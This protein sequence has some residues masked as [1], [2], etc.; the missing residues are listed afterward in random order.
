MAQPSHIFIVG[1]PRS[2]TSVLRNAL[3]CSKNVAICGETHFLG[4][5][6][7]SSSL[8]RYVL[9]RPEKVADRG[10][11]FLL[12]KRPTN[13]G[14]RQAFAKVGDISTDTGAKKVVD[15]IYNSRPTFWRW[16]AEHV[17]REE[18]LHRL[19]ESDRTDRALLDLLMAFY[20][21]GKPIR[22][23]KTPDHI[24]H[25]PTLLEWFPKAKIVHTF[26]DLRAVFVSLREKILKRQDIS[27]RHR[28]LRKS[29][30]LYEAHLSINIAIHWLRVA[31]LHHQ[32][33]QLYPDNYYFC[34]FEDLVHNPRTHLKRICDFLEIDFTE[35]MLHQSF[36][37]SSLIPRHQARGF[38]ATAANR[39]RKH[40]HPLTNKWL[41]W[42]SRKQ[43][44]EFGYQL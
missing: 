18:F 11:R 15:Y 5:P 34:K 28:I 19:L 2:G 16:A 22:G 17:D 3:N 9:N 38:D 26:R 30:L 1:V 8:L 6:R 14:S 31:Q 37:N 29:P 42:W 43:L 41:V 21:N 7:T 10:G 35:A 23:E 4:S 39:W 24:H 33:Q 13:P 36:Q 20:A 25:V 32:F 27:S 12:W 44:L 40:L